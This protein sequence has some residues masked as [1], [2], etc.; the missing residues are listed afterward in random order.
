LA[1]VRHALP[2]CAS[3]EPVVYGRS[4]LSHTCAPA[5][6]SRRAGCWADPPTTSHRVRTRRTGAS[7]GYSATRHGQI[8]LPSAMSNP[9]SFDI[10]NANSTRR[11][12]TYR[13]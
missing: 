12:A 9:T 11:L 13:W 4:Y 6:R 7:D 3:S 8:F 5:P 1:I 2:Y 10:S